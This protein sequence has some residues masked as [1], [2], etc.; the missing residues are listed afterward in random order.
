MGRKS[1]KSKIRAQRKKEET[2]RQQEA[3]NVVRKANEIENP[4]SDF[5][6]FNVFNKN[7]LKVHIEFSRVGDIDEETFQEIF[8]LQKENME[9]VYNSCSWGWDEKKKLSEMKESNAKYLIARTD[10]NAI[11]GFSHFRFD[12]DYGD[13]VLYCYELQL[14]SK[15]RRKGLGKFL[16]QIL[17]LMAFKNN[18]RKVV[19]TVL[20]H[21]T[22]AVDFFHSMRY[23]VDETNP[24]ENIFEV[25]PYEILSKIN[26]RLPQR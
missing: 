3:E 18:M 5:P 9:N 8:K 26:K 24:E 11:V 14:S 20:K 6:A 19:L 23:E 10:D 2:L 1:E 21:N 15:I 17:E 22:S 13:E 7:G 4:L 25:I 12:I 16:L